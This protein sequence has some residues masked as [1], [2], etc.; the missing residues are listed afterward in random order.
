MEFMEH[1][2]RKKLH[3]RRS[4][5]QFLG[6]NGPMKGPAAPSQV[7]SQ[8]GLSMGLCKAKRNP[9]ALQLQ[10]SKVP[11]LLEDPGTS[12]PIH[13]RTCAPFRL[14]RHCAPT[15]L[16]VHKSR[17][18]A[19]PKWSSYLRGVYRYAPKSSSLTGTFSKFSSLCHMPASGISQGK[20]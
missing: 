15:A 20:T 10:P 8:L 11:A 18:V 2:R 9:L 17:R 12:P 13:A 14:M 16:V 7:S 6:T 19:W 5:I 4:F 3:R 1:E